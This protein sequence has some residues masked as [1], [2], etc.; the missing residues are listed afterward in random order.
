MNNSFCP[1]CGTN[2]NGN[3]GS[4]VSFRTVLTNN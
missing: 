1:Y 4:A 3:N 2:T